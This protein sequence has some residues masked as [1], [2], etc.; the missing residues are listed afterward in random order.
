MRR[1]PLRVSR[2]GNGTARQAYIG[3]VAASDAELIRRARK[4]PD[5]FSELYVRHH[6]QLYRWFRSRLP[7]AEAS[8]LTAE[9]FA[10]AAAGADRAAG[11]KPRLSDQHLANANPSQRASCQPDQ[12]RAL[13]GSP[14]D[15]ALERLVAD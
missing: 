14:F 10:Q 8:E 13:R 11:R 15:H 4:D 12:E 3:V 2:N 1:A 9:V 6:A 7:E 5:A